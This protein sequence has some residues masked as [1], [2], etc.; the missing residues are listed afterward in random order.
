MMCI[1]GSVTPSSGTAA[2]FTV[3]AL[4]TWHCHL[5]DPSHDALSSLSRL[6][7]IH[8]S[9][10]KHDLCHACQLGK[11]IRLPFSSLSNRVAMAFDL[12]HVDLWTSLVVTVLGSK[13]YLV[14]LDDFT[15][16]L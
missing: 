3:V 16:Y 7:F 1:P 6:S 14:I 9:S 8:S 2:A 4:A 10:N 15:H 5:G 12:I 13:Y 11:H